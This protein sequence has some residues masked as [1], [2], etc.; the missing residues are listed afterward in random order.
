[1]K[2]PSS[3]PVIPNQQPINPMLNRQHRVLHRLHLLQHNWHLV[4]PLSQEI[5]S[6]LSD[7]SMYRDI[8]LPIPLPLESF[9]ATAPLGLGA[10]AA[11][12]AFTRSSASRLPGVG[13]STVTK[14]ARTPAFSACFTRRVE[15]GRSVFT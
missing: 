7:E 9:A 15:V 11:A 8:I 5:T 10:S 13:W 4:I 3:S 2:Y 12:S 6:Q 14:M 1:M